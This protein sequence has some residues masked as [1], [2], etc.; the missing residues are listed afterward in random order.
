[1]RLFRD[2]EGGDIV[3]VVLK[4][5]LFSVLSIYNS[6]TV[7]TERSHKIIDV[8]VTMCKVDKLIP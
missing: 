7:P 6:Q 1:M 4:N 8:Q 3:L 5:L 2:I